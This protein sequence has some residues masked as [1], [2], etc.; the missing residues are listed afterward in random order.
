MIKKG[1]VFLF[2]SQFLLLCYESPPHSFQFL[3]HL[4]FLFTLF[5]VVLSVLEQWGSLHLLLVLLAIILCHPSL[6][7]LLL[8]LPILSVVIPPPPHIYS[9]FSDAT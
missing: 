2:L 4:S 8:K 7:L 6:P 1:C 9:L 3:S 5:P